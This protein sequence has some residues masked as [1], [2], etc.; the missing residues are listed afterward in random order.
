MD[1]AAQY[2]SHSDAEP[3][4]IV[5][6]RA[7]GGPA[8]G[9]GQ[10]NQLSTGQDQKDTKEYVQEMKQGESK[11]LVAV[12][13]RPMWKK[14]Q[15]RGE[16]GIV[17]ILDR[18][19]VILMDPA[20]VLSEEKVLGK[21][22][23]KEKQYAFDFA[24]DETATQLEMFKNTTKFL[25]EGVLNGYNSTVFAYGQTG[26]GKTYTMLGDQKNPGIM[27]N[28]M[29]E[30]F[31]QMKRHQIDREYT[32]RVSFLE[33]YNENIKDLIMLSNDVL[34]LREDP[35]KGVQ[36]AGL[37]EI[38]VH[39]PDEIFELLVY[40]NKN[41]TQEATNANETSSRSHAVLQII[42][43]YK[44]RDAGVKAEIK[45]GKLSLIDLAGSERAAKT[46][47][48][49]MRMIE[50]AN[51][52]KS[53][54]ALGNCIN[55]LHENNSKGQS[56]YIPFRDSKLTR[57]LKDS[58]GGNCRTVMIANIAPS[59]SNYEDTHNTLKYANRAK[60]IKTNV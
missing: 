8:N 50:G 19:V 21:N 42:C 26:A 18:N 2:L 27:F 6:K 36:V 31:K 40:G 45:V 24:F 58:L 48:R 3:I 46:G 25:C 34:D 33:I 53:L 49:G 55:M 32:V 4:Q 7:G 47:N 14:E 9:A 20:D 35:I 11:I 23:T 5:S 41:R 59:S 54:L 13:L 37:S 39:T 56:N 28:T 15:E 12:R 16:I 22:R 43:E 44:D 29:K 17:K 51:I 57:L 10:A 1:E 60:N 38:E 52:N 30:V